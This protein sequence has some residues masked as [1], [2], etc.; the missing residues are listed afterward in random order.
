ME[1]HYI[2][3]ELWFLSGVDMSNER[4]FFLLHT[5]ASEKSVRA[6]VYRYKCW[7]FWLSHDFVRVCA[8]SNVVLRFC[9]CAHK[10]TIEQSIEIHEDTERWLFENKRTANEQEL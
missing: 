3:T 9:L 2:E 4:E 8:C 5:Y 1:R 7:R 6:F 10:Q